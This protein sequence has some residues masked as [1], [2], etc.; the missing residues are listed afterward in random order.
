MDDPVSRTR[1][2]SSPLSSLSP[3]PERPDAR[4]TKRPRLS[5]PPAVDHP[6]SFVKHRSPSPP[7][8]SSS[9][10]DL[11]AL[12][13]G[14]E[15]RDLDMPPSSDPVARRDGPDV[16]AGEA[17]DQ[18]QDHPDSDVTLTDRT[19]DE[20]GSERGDDSGIGLLPADAKGFVRQRAR[21]PRTTDRKKSP[22]PGTEDEYEGDDMW[23]GFD[24]GEMGF[25]EHDTFL[26]SLVPP[27]SNDLDSV[28]QTSATSGARDADDDEP[29]SL[30]PPALESFGFANLSGPGGFV[31]ATR[32]SF[33][34]SAAALK[35]AQA[36]FDR[37][38]DAMI[39]HA[40]SQP[41][42]PAQSVLPAPSLTES[43][44]R[45]TTTQALPT[46][47]LAPQPVRPAPNVPPVLFGFQN[48]AG[49][50]L[51]PPSEDALQRARRKL[52]RSSSPERSTE[53]R[54]R[55]PFNAPTRASSRNGK[56]DA[57]N[58]GP[59]R[60]SS[61]NFVV[62]PADAMR[63][64]AA[65]DPSGPECDLLESPTMPRT[66]S[67]VQAE[68]F[69]TPVVGRRTP[70]LSVD[71][72]PTSPVIDDA[73]VV[74]P[75]PRSSSPV[76][77]AA[78][79]P[80]SSPKA[81]EAAPATSAFAIPSIP[82]PRPVSHPPIASTSAA[83]KPAQS[84]SR[85]TPVRRQLPFRSP[86]ITSARHAIQPGSST[87]LRPSGL[88]MSST[89]YQVNPAAISTATPLLNRR[90]NIGMTP[91][92]KPFHLAN[93]QS[94]A[95]STGGKA[96]VAKG[97]AKGFVTPFKGGK[98]PDGL[99]PM[100]L[101]EKT[102]AAVAAATPKAKVSKPT[103]TRPTAKRGEQLAGVP[104]R[105]RVFDLAFDG[106]RQTLLEFGMRPQTHFYEHLETLGFSPEILSMD[107]TTSAGYAFPCGR[108][109]R[110]AFVELQDLVS[111][112]C[113]DEKELVTFPWV[114]NHWALI[115]WKLACYARSRPDLKDEWWTFERV[116]E[117]LRYRYERE[118]NHAQRSSIKRIQERDSPASLPL[119]LCVSQIRWGD[120]PED[121][122][123]ADVPLTIVGLELTDGWYRI[124]TNV[125]GTL[126]SA[127]ERGKIVVGT[128]LAIAGAKLESST[129]EGIDVLDALG[130]SFLTISGN[131]TSLA[132]W[133]A[134]LGFQPA[135]FVASFDSLTSTGGVVALID[136][137]VDKVYP[138]G[139][140]DM[141]RGRS[142]ET[143]G[144]DEE[145]ER[146]EA[147]RKG[148]HDIENKLAAKAEEEETDED[149]LVALLQEAV[150][151][152]SDGSPAAARAVR[153]EEEP[154]EVLDRLQAAPNKR[155]ILKSL[156]PG[157]LA[158][159]LALAIEGAA[160]SRRRA[161]EDLQADL[162]DKFP[163]REVR[164]FRLLRVRD[165]REG[166]NG[167]SDR[168]ALLTV[169][170]AESFAGD[171][172]R[173]GRRY[174]VTNTVPKGNWQRKHKEISLGTRR[175]SRWVRIEK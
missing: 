37:D 46:P 152:G 67:F 55:P 85:E 115:V 28:E 2:A 120:P 90:L 142:S 135:G 70:L 104:H 26:S 15:E 157:V 168:E 96:G 71:N 9:Q 19:E 100:G 66:L 175:D 49:R 22:A 107:L 59:A 21:P 76:P 154:D 146:A 159:V 75:V 127:C 38:D 88:S 20:L 81:N 140:L 116:T 48:A 166:S 54:S 60:A 18:V 45:S 50:S 56:V 69:E 136:V 11:A 77:T 73:K 91:R 32:K 117:Q 165:A 145:R 74:V 119:V 79:G 41:E 47:L 144:A 65:F 34:P 68:G 122:D 14:L 132:R 39:E 105:A 25:D 92:N 82:P 87:P 53:A 58:Q 95:S 61:R 17:G 143:W 97:R 24:D 173:E 7:R 16:G 10:D 44:T 3:S 160:Q 114:K 130:R 147:W 83:P 57:L 141:R 8:T 52:D 131:S 167:P 102:D 36:L 151:R 111:S 1:A 121:I 103:G 172:F 106:P 23:L 89:A 4:P 149:K 150:Q 118:I 126:R 43:K 174:T 134:A 137:V 138:C 164:C 33:A 139:Y 153:S 42:P 163:P 108:T 124:R 30:K 155:A 161:V 40:P 156:P 12:L 133:D 63:T 31:F 125:D 35:R 86:L 27:A 84:T 51:A 123:A 80:P 128:K 93:T 171:F 158:D 110:D 109:S 99:T 62:P 94:S 5:S 78:L 113:P 6:I 98:R 112:R 101:K 129:S 170:D 169:W 64:S 29:S 13:D 162:V 72:I 148:R